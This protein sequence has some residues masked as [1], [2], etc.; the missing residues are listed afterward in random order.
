MVVVLVEVVAVKTA[1]ELTVVGAA[2]AVVLS[3]L[4][5]AARSRR[6]S[7]IGL[8]KSIGMRRERYRYCAVEFESV[9][10]SAVLS[11]VFDFVSI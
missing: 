8:T 11:S 9:A 7:F 6:T 2:A 1:P 5:V 4:P 3:L 10:V